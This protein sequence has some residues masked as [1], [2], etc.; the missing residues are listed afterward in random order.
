MDP[1]AT[2][3]GVRSSWRINSTMAR[4]RDEAPIV[5]A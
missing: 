1:D 3:S 5:S 4:S 2:F